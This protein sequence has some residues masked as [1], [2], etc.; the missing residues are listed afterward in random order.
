MVQYLQ[1]DRGAPSHHGKARQSVAP[2]QFKTIG[3][4]QNN[5]ESY[6]WQALTTKGMSP[7]Q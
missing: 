7:N 2:K 5:G 4:I 3:T 6:N 1:A